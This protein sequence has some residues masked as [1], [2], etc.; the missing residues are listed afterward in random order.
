MTTKVVP[1]QLVAA[2]DPAEVAR[3]AAT[4]MADALRGAIRKNGRATM[5]LSGGNTP[6]AAYA[7]LAAMPAIDWQNV[8]LFWVDERAVP[9]TDDRS[10]YRWAKATLIDP[11][12]VP[13]SNVHRMPS[14]VP[15]LAGAARAYE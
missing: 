3:E 5:A 2:A 7:A 4:R 11:A 15:D 1:G 8:A 9:A 6:R 14:E 10:N 12:H 13:A